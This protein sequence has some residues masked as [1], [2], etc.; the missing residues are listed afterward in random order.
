MAV[1]DQPL[2]SYSDT[3]PHKKV[4]SDYIDNIDPRDTPVV[5]YFGLSNSPGKFRLVNWPSTTVYWLQDTL[6]ILTD[7][8]AASCTSN[9]TTLSV[10]DGSLHHVGDVYKIDLEYVWISSISTNTLT[11]TRNHGGTQASHANAATIT[12]ITTARLDGA[13]GSYDRAVS[14]ITQGFNYTQI[15]QDDLQ[16]ARTLNEMSQYG[17]VREFDYQAA[18]KFEEQMILMEKTFF[19]GQ[20]QAGSATRGRAMGGIKTYVT[21]NTASLSG[22]ALTQQDLEDRVM[23]IWEQGGNPN[24]I[25]CNGW[26]KRKLSSFFEDSVRTER[27]EQRGGVVITHI[28]TEFGPFEIL[29]SRWCPK[30]ELYI[31]ESDYVGFMAFRP[32]FQ[33]PLAQTG[34]SQKGQILGEYT[35]VFKNDKAHGYISSISTS[36]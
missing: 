8:L 19:E 4:I 21:T 12:R 20:R 27:S 3:T 35:L 17:I 22:A 24:L 1:A 31:V 5:K 34:D 29:M 28:D 10:T 18:K 15:F 23:A 36:S 32:F 25:I 2:T 9:A 16:V 11:V 6:A 13:D 33:E 26:V 14:D 30:D 7:T